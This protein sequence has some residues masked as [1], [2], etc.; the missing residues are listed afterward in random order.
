MSICYHIKGD[1]IRVNRVCHQVRKF[2]K[3][4]YVC[5]WII[6]FFVVVLNLMQ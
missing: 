5:V 4:I 1:L 2:R 3:S 6:L